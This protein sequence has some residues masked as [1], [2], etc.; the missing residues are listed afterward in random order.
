MKSLGL[1]VC[2]VLSI[3]IVP[4]PASAQIDEDLGPEPPPCYGPFVVTGPEQR[5]RER[6]RRSADDVWMDSVLFDYGERYRDL[7]YA[8]DVRHICVGSSQTPF[9]KSARFRCMV[10]AKPC[11]APA[12]RLERVPPTLVYTRAKP[13]PPTP[14]ALGPST[15]PAPEPTGQPTPEPPAQPVPEPS[16]QPAPEP[17]ARPEAEQ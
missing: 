10:S 6:A 15:Q 4:L 1:G 16:A 3:A 9:L 11:Q 12:M 7:N 2:I 8:K 5:T 17:S 13:E 14:P